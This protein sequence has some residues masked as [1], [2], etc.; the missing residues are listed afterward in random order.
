MEKT[1]LQCCYT[2][3]GVVRLLSSVLRPFHM[4]AVYCADPVFHSLIMSLL[5]ERDNSVIT[6]SIKTKNIVYANS[7][8]P[9]GNSFNEQ[10]L[11]CLRCSAENAMLRIQF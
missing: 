5:F 3:A 11:G 6:H 8:H 10:L 2:E 4:S 1:Q 7:V 9:L